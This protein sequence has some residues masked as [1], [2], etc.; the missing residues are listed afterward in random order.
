M[1]I[2][3]IVLLGMNPNI[4][5]PC[6]LILQRILVPPLCIRPTV[7]VDAST[8]NEDDLTTK[9]TEIVFLNNVIQTNMQSG[10]Q[11][12]SAV[13]TKLVISAVVTKLVVSAVVIKLV[14]S[15]VVGIYW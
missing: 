8:T 2:Y 10:T 4:G 12:I 9:L 6:D 7:E 15:D 11:V 13:V 5:R 14:I 3:Q 1:I